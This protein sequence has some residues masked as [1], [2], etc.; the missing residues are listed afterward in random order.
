[1]SPTWFT[2]FFINN[3]GNDRV[4]RIGLSPFLSRTEPVD[5]KTIHG[6]NVLLYLYN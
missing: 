2:R 6:L 5:K 3:G 4:V 1:M